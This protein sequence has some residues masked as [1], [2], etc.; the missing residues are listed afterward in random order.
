VAVVPVRVG[1]TVKSYLTGRREWME[2]I[3]EED[4][5]QLKSRK[6]EGMK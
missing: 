4:V 3:E 2:H 5:K 6:A 1:Q